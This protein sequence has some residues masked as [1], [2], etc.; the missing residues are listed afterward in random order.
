V[1]IRVLPFL[2]APTERPAIRSNAGAILNP[3]PFLNRLRDTLV[4][5]AR[6]ISA[7]RKLA[8]KTQSVWSVPPLFF[9][10]RDAQ[11][12]LASSRTPHTTFPEPFLHQLAPKMPAEFAEWNRLHSALDNAL[13]LLPTSINTRR[14]AR[15]TPGLCEAAKTLAPVFRASRELTELLAVPDDQVI[16]AIHPTARVGI[17]V[18]IRGVSNLFQLHT[19]LAAEFYNNRLLTGARIDAR[20]VHAYLNADP[21]PDFPVMTARFQLFRPN[22]LNLDGTLPI[23]FSGSDKWVWGNESPTAFSPEH[24]ERVVLLGDAAYPATWEVGRQFPRLSAEIRSIEVL[25]RAEVE[26]WL[27]ARCPQLPR[28]KPNRQAA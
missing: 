24:G 2:A 16:L 12:V 15:A 3:V 21:D 19:L 28:A 22:A 26:S 6:L 4:A 8:T 27:S 25:N 1:S 13:T 11:A 14:A 17:R 20:I 5:S 9:F 23:G 7:C 10:D 18:Q